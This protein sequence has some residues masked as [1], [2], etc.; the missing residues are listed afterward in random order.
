[1]TKQ[2]VHKI[3][4]DIDPRDVACTTYQMRNPFIQ[5]ADAFASDLDVHCYHQHAFAADLCPKDGRVLDVCCGRG[6]LIP[7]LRYRAKPS[8]Y[9]GVDVCPNNAK[10]KDGKDPRRESRD[11]KPWPFE[12]VFVE[13][14]VGQ[15][16][17][18]VRKAVG[19]KGFDL[20]VYTSSIEHMHPDEQINSLK[21]IA[22]LSKST[23]PLYLSCPVTPEGR[24]GFDTQY[25]AH[26]YEPKMSEIKS[27]LAKAGFRI[28]W[29]AGLGSKTSHVKNTL[30]GADLKEALRILKVQPREQALCTI[31]VLFPE[32]AT[33]VAVLAKQHLEFGYDA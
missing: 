26:V 24:D 28:E 27:M 31:A 8:L 7:F 11:A 21:A 25:S 4:E 3:T 32:C 29:T 23:A 10:W 20:V 12:T 16:L 33:E 5:F 1:M 30:K 19:S 14:R 17:K 9:C 22:K 2:I 6:L 13:S 18:P 15:M